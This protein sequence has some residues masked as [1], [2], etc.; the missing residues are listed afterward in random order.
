MWRLNV[1]CWRLVADHCPPAVRRAIVDLV[2]WGIGMRLPEGMRAATLDMTDVGWMQ[3]G[4]RQQRKVVDL[5]AE[6]GW[7]EFAGGLR[8]AADG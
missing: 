5:C 8:S 1:G 3:V 6:V 4:L 7:S 2:A